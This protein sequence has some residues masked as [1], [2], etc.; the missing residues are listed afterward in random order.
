MKRGKS[1]VAAG[2]GCASRLLPDVI[3][4]NKS[5]TQHLNR[6]GTRGWRA[7]EPAVS[8]DDRRKNNSSRRHRRPC[9][10]VSSYGAENNTLDR[11][12]PARDGHRRRSEPDRTPPW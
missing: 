12:S 11:S 9:A 8:P 7:E 5:K 10:P 2:E 4:T 1:T 6:H 3:E